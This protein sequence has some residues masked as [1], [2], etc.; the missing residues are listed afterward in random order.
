MGPAPVPFEQAPDASHQP[1]PVIDLQLA[2]SRPLEQS[3]EPPMHAESVYAQSEPQVPL[4]GPL[5][6]P[7][8]QRPVSPHQPQPEV[9][10]Q[11]SHVRLLA[12]RSVVEPH[13]LE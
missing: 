2:Q 10:A 11:V 1:Q 5:E 12:Q 13:S 4:V 7:L 9:L 8:A 6:L 3:D